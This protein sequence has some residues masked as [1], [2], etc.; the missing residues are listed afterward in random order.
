MV[1][2]VPD[3]KVSLD[4]EGDYTVVTFKGRTPQQVAN[5][6]HAALEATEAEDTFAIDVRKVAQ[7]ARGGAG[8]AGAGF[9][10]F[11]FGR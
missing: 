9:G 11:G 6:L 2:D 3:N 7:E 5:T 4:Y 10:G 1:L 8:G